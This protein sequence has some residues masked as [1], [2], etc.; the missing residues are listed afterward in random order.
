MKYKLLALDV[1][2]TLV[3][4]D[5]RVDP[6]TRQALQ[7][8]CRE[9]LGVCLATGRTFKE[10]VEIWKQI[11]L[12][13]PHEPMIVLGGAM[14]REP[15][16]GRTLCLRRID[17]DAAGQLAQA[18]LAE[19]CSVVA[20]LDEWRMGYDYLVVPGR[21]YK[22]VRS[23]WL[24]RFP[25]EVREC[26]D[27]SKADL[28]AC[29][30]LIA[31]IDAAG[32]ADLERRLSERFGSRLHLYTIYAPTFDMTVVEAYA[33]KVNKA[34][35]VAYVAQAHGLG[36]G[37]V[38]AVGDDVND[39]QLLDKAGLGAVMP[40]ASQRVRR[41]ADVVVEGSLGRFVHDLLDGRYDDQ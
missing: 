19:G 26:E 14:V 8:A 32:A 20:T 41:V 3:G 12:P 37:A 25:V 29:G 33:P 31:M 22:Q 40:Q 28:S 9:G 10:T 27:I 13:E 16:R 11:Q 7:R 30:R 15:L 5:Q 34:S 2:G 4:P 35:G 1:D 18:L 38:A 17:P 24:D 21:D 23:Q 39:L 36:L 6:E